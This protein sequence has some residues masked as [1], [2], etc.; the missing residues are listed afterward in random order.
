MVNAY[1]VS[2]LRFECRPPIIGRFVIVQTNVHSDP[3]ASVDPSLALSANEI[4][5]FGK[6]NVS[7]YLYCVLFCKICSFKSNYNV[8][9]LF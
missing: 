3:D 5:V 7:A 8:V 6:G 1:K 4:K 2:I 9:K